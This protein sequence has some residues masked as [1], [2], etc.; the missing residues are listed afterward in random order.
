MKTFWAICGVCLVFLSGTIFNLA[1]AASPKGP[2]AVVGHGRFHSAPD[3]TLEFIKEQLLA[4]AFQDVLAKELNAMDF[5]ATEFW[6]KY[7]AA[8][9]ESF[10]GTEEKFKERLAAQAKA[11]DERITKAED[12]TQRSKLRTRKN[13]VI[14]ELEKNLRLKKLKAHSEFEN[15]GR[16]IKSF[17]IV[18][19]ARATNDPQQRSITVQA[20]VDRPY[21]AQLYNRLMREQGQTAWGTLY[22]TTSFNLENISWAEI[23]GE[24]LEAALVSTWTNWGQEQWGDLVQQVSNS[25]SI[26]SL[27]QKAALPDK[28]GDLQGSSL[29]SQDKPDLWLQIK[30]HVQQVTEDEFSKLKRIVTQG[31]FSLLALKTGKILLSGVLG[32][33]NKNYSTQEVHDF[34]SSLATTISAAAVEAFKKVRPALE[35]TSSQIHAIA[36]EVK[37]P[38]SMANALEILNWLKSNGIRFQLGGSL[39]KYSTGH[40]VLVISSAANEQDFIGLMNLLAKQVIG[41]HR[42]K[43]DPE[44]PYT[45][46]LLGTRGG[47]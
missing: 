12:S 40:A 6:Q 3:D 37:N 34:A 11:W 45:C 10:R 31:E 26:S 43:Y 44:N 5:S 7:E 19:M 39:Q 1:A 15:V 24:Q 4:S 46:E 42:M 29:W 9:A 28:V 23:G 2:E 21:L 38:G 36:L 33:A 17:S 27:E 18:K 22:L 32:E 8:F 41:G 25:A 47:P 30:L 14:S 35:N 13:E 20:K 16:A